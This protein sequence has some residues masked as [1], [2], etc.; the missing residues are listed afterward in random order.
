MCGTGFVRAGG[1]RR[2]GLAWPGVIIV[3]SDGWE[4]RA[5][6]SRRARYGEDQLDDVSVTLDGRMAYVERD[7]SLRRDGRSV[8]G[9]L[10]DVTDNLQ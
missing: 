6:A 3:S 8:A 10:C 5:Y 9:G 4:H 2:F 7:P 1:L